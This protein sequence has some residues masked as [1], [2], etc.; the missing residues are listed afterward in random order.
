MAA[1]P[2][3]RLASSPTA[4]A[5]TPAVRA[6]YQ[7]LG[8]VG[9]E[10]FSAV[11]LVC[12]CNTKAA[13]DNTYPNRVAVLQEVFV[14]ESAWLPWPSGQALLAPAAHGALAHPYHV[15]RYVNLS[16]AASPL[17]LTQLLFSVSFSLT[18]VCP[19]T[20]EGPPGQGYG[21]SPVAS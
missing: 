7:C 21:Y 2:W 3:S 14:Y 17:R 4:E 18:F 6:T 10:T 20:V 9:H 8:R 12:P 11:T 16:L 19:A 5:E 1:P 13:P 15:N